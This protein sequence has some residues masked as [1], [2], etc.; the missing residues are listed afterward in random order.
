MLEDTYVYMEI[1]LPIDGEGTDF[2]KVTKCLRDG[3]G[4]S[5]GSSHENSMLDTR[6]YEVEYLDGHEASL[7]VNNTAENISSQVDEICN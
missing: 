6:F 7:V 4:I 3:N 5:I 1:R 2:T